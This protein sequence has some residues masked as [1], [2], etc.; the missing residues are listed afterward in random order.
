MFFSSSTSPR[1]STVIFFDRSP[2]ATARATSAMLR[3][4]LVRLLAI[5]FTF[6]VSSSQMPDDVAHDRLAAEHAFGADLARHT[7]DLARR[8]TPSESTMALMVFF[9]CSSS[10][11]TST[12]IFFDRSP[13]A[14]AVVTAG[15][16]AHLVGQVAA[17]QVDVVGQLLPDARHV[18]DVGLHA[19]GAFGADQAGHPVHLGARSGSACRRWR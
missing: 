6:W 14:T 13:L 5:E 11:L 10:P 16:V 3:T 17:H 4:W 7:R 2:L 9:S 15:D 18:L 12:V 1:A 8:T 19:Q